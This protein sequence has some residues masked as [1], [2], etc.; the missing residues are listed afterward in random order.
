M[1]ALYDEIPPLVFHMSP[2]LFIY[3]SVKVNP[4]RM[5]DALTFLNS[6]KPRSEFDY[7]FVE[8]LFENQYRTDEQRGRILGSF[9]GL[10][11]FIACLGLFG[12]AS[13]TAEQRTKEIG[14]RKVLGASVTNI[15]ML[16]SKEFVLMVVLAN[17]I[18]WPVA[19]YAMSRWLQDFAYRIEPGPGVFLLGGALALLIALLTVSAQA[20]KAARANPVD[21]L[22]YE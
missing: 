13:F 2:D 1:Q 8:D 12:L 7:F 5:V 4:D 10:A 18:A 16:L 11:I 9:A 22:R 15:V 14:I 20:V 3:V 19:Y 21:V 6:Q 17:L